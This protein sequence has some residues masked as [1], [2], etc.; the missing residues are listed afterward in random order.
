MRSPQIVHERW[1]RLPH[2]ATGMKKKEKYFFV[3]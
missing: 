3:S 2:L 1:Q